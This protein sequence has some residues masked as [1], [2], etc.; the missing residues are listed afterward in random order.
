MKTDVLNRVARLQKEPA[1]VPAA[2]ARSRGP[3]SAE[4]AFERNLADFDN[5]PPWPGEWDNSSR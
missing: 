5:D 2:E 1:D 4:L 3:T